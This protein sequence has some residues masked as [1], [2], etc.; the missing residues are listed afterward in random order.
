MGTKLT[1]N[2]K[3]EDGKK[4]AK[5]PGQPLPKMNANKKS[6]ISTYNFVPKNRIFLTVLS[7]ASSFNGQQLFQRSCY[8]PR[9]S[10]KREH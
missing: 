8:Q 1:D 4:S 10:H 9:R 3:L 2:G 5:K 6:E 7:A